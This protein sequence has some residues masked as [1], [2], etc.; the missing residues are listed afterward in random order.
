MPVRVDQPA[1]MTP[2]AAR[3]TASSLSPTAPGPIEA[4]IA[5]IDMGAPRYL[6]PLQT[7]P[8]AWS[9]TERWIALDRGGD[10]ALTIGPAATWHLRPNMPYLISLRDG[11]GAVTEDRMS[12]PAIRLPSSAPPSGRAGGASAPADPAPVT[13]IDPPS[14]PMDHFREMAEDAP[15]PAPPPKPRG[16][17]AMAL[18]ILVLLIAVG[19]GAYLALNDPREPAPDQITALTPVRVAPTVVLSLDGARGYLKTSP[20]GEGAGAEA[21]RFDAAGQA[22]AAFLLHA[23]AARN[24]A[25][26]S[27]LWLGM[28]YDPATWTDGVVRAAD[29]DRA[30]EH[31]RKAAN[32]GLPEAME[33]LAALLASGDVIGADAKDAARWRDKA[34]AAKAD[35]GKDAQ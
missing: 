2:G 26:A 6:D 17:G 20:P 28:R 16:K 32:A 21:A 35:A 30:A 14:D 5:R 15:A 18:L 24:G 34:R 8:E 9:P 25:A 10:G 7:G 33:R 22:D 11:T 13:R 19:A 4:R 27:S 23:Y 3:L 12:W 31:Y 1:D 29:P